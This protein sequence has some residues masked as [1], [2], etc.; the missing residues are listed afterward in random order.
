[1]QVRDLLHSPQNRRMAPH[2]Q[3]ATQERR[4]K[5]DG[6]GSIAPTNTT[7]RTRFLGV[8]VRDAD[9][10]DTMNPNNTRS[11]T[12]WGCPLCFLWSPKP[13]PTLICCQGLRQLVLS[14][15]ALR[16]RSA[17]PGFLRHLSCVRLGSL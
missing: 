17:F 15:S 12:T 5:S 6:F 10:A 4:G 8:L 14:V 3:C 2:Q 11:A 9:K 13:C 16:Q 7:E 1:M